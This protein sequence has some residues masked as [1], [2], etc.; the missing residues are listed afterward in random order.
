MTCRIC[1]SEDEYPEHEL[2]QACQ[3]AGSMKYIGLSCIKQWLHGKRHCKETRVVNSYIWKNLECEL[4]KS[5]FIDVVF[6]RMG[7]EIN[8]LNFNLFEDS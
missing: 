5:P 7:H 3:C 1:L 2:I 8:L 4:C 6:S